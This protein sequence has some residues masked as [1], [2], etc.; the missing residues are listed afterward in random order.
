MEDDWLEEKYENDNGCAYEPL[1]NYSEED[2]AEIM[3]EDE[4][5]FIL[6]HDSALFWSNKD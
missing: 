5:N 1:D 2:F 4:E 6:E 3:D